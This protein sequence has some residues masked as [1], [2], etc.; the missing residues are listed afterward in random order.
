MEIIIIYFLLIQMHEEATAM[1]E[2]Y[3]GDVEVHF[4]RVFF[5]MDKT[6][7]GGIQFIIRQIRVFPIL[8]PE[9]SLIFHDASPT[10]CYIYNI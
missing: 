1:E 6:S 10:L 8:V 5:Y 3:G 7:P 4:S 9:I 2:T